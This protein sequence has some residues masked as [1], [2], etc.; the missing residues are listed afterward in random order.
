MASLH[1]RVAAE[2]LRLDR[3]ELA[4]SIH[5]LSALPQGLSETQ[6]SI[7]TGLLAEIPKLRPP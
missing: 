5:T 3:S 4:S 7:V 2:A 6:L 1:G